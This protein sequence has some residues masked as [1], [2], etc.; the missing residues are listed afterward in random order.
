MDKTTAERIAKRFVGL[1]LEQRR[2][3][4]EKMHATGQSFK[5]LP[6]AVTRHDVAR[7]PLS[8][9]QQRMLFLWQLEPTSSFYN[10]PM[11]VRLTGDL[12]QA[13]LAE[14]LALLVQ[15]HETLRTR[16]ISEEGEFYQQILDHCDVFLEHADVDAQA[17]IEALVK[18][19]LRRPFD[20]LNDPLL[21]VKLLRVDAT[22][23]VLTVC[24][25]HIVSDGWSS[26]LM[27]ETFVQCYDGLVSGRTVDLAPLSIQYADYA[28]WQRAWLEAGEGERQL[29]Y[30]QQQ[31]GGEQPVLELPLDHP[32]PAQASYKGA[33]VRADVPAALA[34]SLK[35]LAQKNGQTLFMLMLAAVAV[36]L[37]RY[38]GQSDIRVG[39]PNAGRNRKDLEGLIGFFINTQVMR[40]QVDECATFNGLLEQVKAVVGG[41]QSHQ[42]LPFEQLVDA[43][44][45]ERNLSHNPLFQFKLNQNVAGEASSAGARKTLSGLSVEEFPLSGA[46]ARFDLAFDFSDSAQGI[47]AYFTYATD[48]FEAPTIQRIAESLQQVLQQLAQA[49]ASRLLDQPRTASTALAGDAVTFAHTD[50]LGL[51]QQALTGAGDKPALRC[52]A[53]VVSYQQLER[54]S[55]QL[56]AYLRQ[57]GIGVGALVALSQERTIEWVTSI[58]AVLKTGAAFLPLDGAQPAERLQQ[59]L[60]DSEAAL[61]IRPLGD[62]T[63][64]RLHA[65][66]VLAFDPAIWA[67]CSD[68]TVNLDVLPAQT[69][70]VIYTSGSTGQPK[71]VVLSHQML[72]NYLQGVLERLQVPAGASMAMASTV[73]ADLGHTMLFGALAS[74]R[75]LHL[76]SKD[77]AFDPD[78]FASYMSEHQVDVLKIV[79]SHLQGLLQAANPA[80]VLPRQLLVVGG[81]ACPWS[82]AQKVRQLRPDCRV[83]NH[84]GPTETTVGILTHEV[85]D[86]LDGYRSVPIGQPLANSCV[87]VLDG[88]LNP[89]PER[90]AGELYLGGQGVAHGYLGRAALTA[91]RFVPDPEAQYGERLYRAGDRARIEQGRVEF[92]GRADEQV[93]IR[94][95]RVEPGEIAELLRQL[96]GVQDA[97]VLA[98]AL[99]SD[100]ERLQ[101][102]AYCVAADGVSVVTL[103]AQLQARLPDYMVPA[104]ILLL[105][106]LPLTPNGKLDKRALPKPEVVSRQYVAPVGEVEEKL[107]SVW[108]D[109]L[110]LERVG[111]S[112]NFFELGGDSILSLQIIARAKRQGIKITPKQLFEKQTVGLLAQVAK[113]IEEKPRAASTSSVAGGVVPLLPIQQR[114]FQA[115]I[116][117]RQRWNQSVLLTPSERLSA[118]ALEAALQ[119]VMQAHDALRLRFSEQQGQWRA[120]FQAPTASSVLWHNTLDDAAHLTNAADEAQGSLD[121]ERGQLVRAVLFDLPDG[122]QRLLVVIHHLVVD[123]VSWRVLLEDLQ[124]AYQQASQGTPVVLA[125]KSSALQQWAEHLSRYASGEALAA[126]RDYWLAALGDGEQELP[127]D[128][129]EGAMTHQQAAHVTSRLDKALT[130]QLLKLA[131]AAY[132]TQVNDLL[133][134]A[135]ARTLCQ[136]SGQ[137]GVSIALEGHGREDLFDD[138]DLSRTVGWFTSLFPVRLTPHAGVGESIK[139]I[140]QQLWQVPHKGVG[141]GVLRYLGD[142]GYASQLR[143]LPEARVTFNYLGQFDGSFSADQGALFVPASEDCGRRQDD[144]APLGNWLSINGQVYN[145]E[146]VLDWTYSRDMFRE[147]TL[148]QLASAYERSLKEVIEHCLEETSQGVTPGDFPLARLTQA[149]LDRLPVAARDIED[150]YPLSPMQE[151]LLLHT[152]LEPGSGIYMMQYCYRVEHG[153]DVPAFMEAWKVVVGR[154]E[155]LRTSFNW[156]VSERMVQIVHRRQEPVIRFYDWQ[157]VDSADYESKLAAELAEELRQ[158]FDL[159]REVPFRLRLIQLAPERFGF[160]FSNHHVLLDA[161]CRMGIV[162]EF[163]KV[164]EGLLKG[165]QVQLPVPSRYRD[166]IAL[167]EG[168]DQD[169]SKAFWRDNLRGF[170]RPTPLPFDHTIN[171]EQGQA[172]VDDRI[173]YFSHEQSAA[174]A[175]KAQSAQLTVNTLVQGAWAMLLQRYSGE[176]DVL[177]G[178]TVAGRPVEFPEMQA[179]VG[180]FINSIPLRVALPGAGSAQTAKAWL[181]AMFEHNLDLREHEHLPLVTIQGCSEIG[182][183]QPLFDSLFVFENAPVE[184][185]VGV[186]AASMNV[187]AGT[188]RTHTN[189]PITVVVYPGEVLGLHLSYD[190]RLF[191]AATIDALLADFQATLLTLAEGL[192]QPFHQLPAL[193]QGM[194]EDDQLPAALS[195]GYAR[196]FAASAMEHRQRVAASSQGRSWRYEELDRQ[197]TQLAQ[198]LQAR[199]I[200]ADGLV[201]VLGERDLP[202]LGMVVA[203]FKAGGGYLSLDPGLPVKRLVDVLGL[204]KASVLV[205]DA[206]CQPLA[207]QVL[208]GLAQPPVLLV[209]E[210]V[211]AQ[212]PLATA[213]RGVPEDAARLLAY[214]I[215]TSGSTGVP[216]GV[217]V[218]QA[219]MLNNQLSKI[220]YL[221]LSSADVIAQTASQSF[222][223]SVWQLLTAALCGARVE[224]IADAIAQDPQRLL[225]HVR[226]SGVS[227]L[228]CVPAMIQAVLE[229]PAVPLPALRYLLTTGE[230]M[231]PA[232]AQRWL[233][234]YPQIELINAYGPAECSDDVALY[235]VRTTGEQAH[236][237]IGTRTDHNRLYVLNDLLE[238]MPVRATGELHIAGV[239]VGRGY[240]GDPLRT[241]LSFVPDPFSARPGER[242]YRSGDL[243]RQQP[244]TEVL[245]YIGRADFQVKIRG[246]R[247]ELGEIEARLQ[248]HPALLSVVVVDVDGAGGK[249]LVAYCVPRDLALIDAGGQALGEL[250]ASLAEHVRASLPGYMVPAQWVMLAALPLTANGKLDRKALPQPDVSQ[251]QQDYVAPVSALEQQMAA[252]WADV[253]KVPQVGLTDNFF[254]LGGHSLLVVQVVVR[255]REQLSIEV[256]LRELFEHSTLAAFSRVAAGKQDQ[257]ESIH[258][259]LAKS[260]EALKRLTTEEIDELI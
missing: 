197:T 258:S 4:L 57:Q 119:A 92:L 84:Y 173:V 97:V 167:L 256:S 118:P 203:T 162:D 134:T 28:I 237:P 111:T 51:W 190:Q 228:E 137:A 138:V 87:R 158:G 23:H 219:G 14:A 172:T 90:V 218:E 221:G 202:L 43:L 153:I 120:E 96:D 40:V 223:I 155:V 88:G 93:K 42:E 35:A 103:A 45:P 25:H 135:L 101:L 116:P 252:I 160:V 66:P 95:Y 112:D 245:E 181:Q 244:D 63:L 152:L 131:P 76:L 52:G 241:A 232:L 185:S 201:A 220:P 117:Q 199:G 69:A 130:H 10:I 260:L 65:C 183:G 74:G 70:Y 39:V 139:H 257:S 85:Q 208:D 215:F 129:P 29:Q 89:V 238:P 212:P 75:L 110:K 31:L 142:E 177:F 192:D 187:Q 176:R 73:A 99:D 247:I 239:G 180:L 1:P 211:Q 60:V 7:I 164:Y 9:A 213:L 12:N 128:S 157:H 94:G 178:I 68:A 217:M 259:E 229:L 168:W 225:E 41:A 254:E 235:R 188:S 121:L 67:E 161:W 19:E 18:E 146:L 108:A 136:W 175:H 147:E 150:I 81:E 71:G 151:G 115:S 79:P 64:A 54:Q 106:R 11:A 236:L 2:Q 246:Y 56:A 114:F 16:L 132:R 62:E 8:Y 53:Q 222:D 231:P 27:I 122:Q 49:P 159:A 251:L 205:C 109:V 44:A 105:E 193:N 204:S 104:H 59:L 113:Q 36:V 124:T 125:A 144:H 77:H 143:A 200:E 171:R 210:Q 58:L 196:L 37:S 174:L 38:S 102:V 50:F 33:V 20:L 195:Q 126:E 206:A 86:T 83:V 127:C 170:E 242:L 194:G 21:R 169:A 98:Q 55:N 3:I 46:D 148:Q 207:Q 78:S 61:L 163:F 226:S 13:A 140:K 123:G 91:E 209:W 186:Q 179:T 189:Y 47:E 233:E 15:R 48:L 72:A 24:M 166:F 80:N 6:I 253:L 240:L 249:Q 224:I 22:H 165:E 154:H 191:E 34:A 230:A 227:V 255:V 216:K 234:R 17:S 214:V 133:L 182:A 32:R 149:Q 145:G 156:E 100:P 141:Y 26:E 243:A 5:L 184:S 248:S 107:A 30:W 250:R 82:L 198:A